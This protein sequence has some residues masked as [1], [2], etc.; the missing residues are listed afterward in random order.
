MRLPRRRDC[1]ELLAFDELRWRLR[2]GMPQLEGQAT[3]RTDDI[4]GTVGRAADF[5]RCFQPRTRALAKR[6]RDIRNAQTTALD[7]P[8]DVIRVDRAY[9]VSDGHKRVSIARSQ[10]QEWI[11]A[12]VSWAPSHFVVTP[13]VTS[14][15]IDRTAL[16]QRF[17]TETGLATAVPGARFAVSEPE[18][19]PQLREALEAYGYE[20]M[21]RSGRVL[22]REEAAACWY[23]LVYLPTL[24]VAEGARLTELLACATPSDLFLA[25]HHQCRQLWGVECVERSDSDEDLAAELRGLPAPDASLI[26]KLVRRARRRSS[27]ELLAER[28]DA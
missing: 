18:G 8:I 7:E 13:G 2:I 21:Q 27:P 5:D 17:R 10:G 4:V 19:Y 22:S 28:Q 24:R 26:E 15:A 23:E 1:G 11:D 9:F 16:E 25:L 6:I 12:N 3:I 20:L 14:E